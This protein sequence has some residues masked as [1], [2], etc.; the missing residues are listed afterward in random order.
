MM[1]G[2]LSTGKP[3]L[4]GPGMTTESRCRQ[5]QVRVDKQYPIE[6]DEVPLNEVQAH[7]RGEP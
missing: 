6:M 1:E 7:K 4:L 5:Y 2:Y 3:L